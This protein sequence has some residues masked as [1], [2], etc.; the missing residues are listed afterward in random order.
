[1]D[2]VQALVA[3]LVEESGTFPMTR[4]HGGMLL[5]RIQ[6]DGFFEENGLV[7]TAEDALYCQHYAALA[8]L[9]KGISEC[10]KL[11]PCDG[12]SNL[13]EL[14]EL[15]C[16]KDLP[17]YGRAAFPEY[18]GLPHEMLPPALVSLAVEAVSGKPSLRGLGDPDLVHEWTI[19]PGIRLFKEFLERLRSSPA[20]VKAFCAP[21]G[22]ADLLRDG[23]MGESQV[24]A[25]VAQSMLLILAPGA[26]WIPI[27]VV[28][29][30]ILVKRGLS[31]L[32]DKGARRSK[33]TGTADDGGVKP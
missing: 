33:D 10:L 22:V 27:A 28:A 3:E 15:V 11:N 17:T 8:I 24:I 25:A 1:M 30:T 16:R 5:R 26:F 13:D 32:C 21:G 19:K 4:P 12:A 2:N 9:A 31:L 29:S 18:Q 14:V 23:K 6:Q 20:T 7:V